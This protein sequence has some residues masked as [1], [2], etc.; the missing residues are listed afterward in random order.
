MIIKT[1][2]AAKQ[3]TKVQV[4]LDFSEPGASNIIGDMMAPKIEGIKMIRR[5]TLTVKT[6]VFIFY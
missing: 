6:A 2:N 1:G 4:F 3:Q 5:I